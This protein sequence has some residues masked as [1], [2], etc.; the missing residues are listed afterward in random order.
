M[1][2]YQKDST[3]S[4]LNHST[5]TNMM[6]QTLIPKVVSETQSQTNATEV[7]I[8]SKLMDRLNKLNLGNN[9]RML[10]LIANYPEYGN[11]LISLFKSL[12]DLNKVLTPEIEHLIQR[13]ICHLGGV[14]NLL[15]LLSENN[16]S[17]DFISA[18]SLF[19]AAK[20][21]ETVAQAVRSL[22]EEDLLDTS[23]F[24]LMLAYP[25]ASLKMS[26]FIIDLQ[27]R[28]YSGPESPQIFVDKLR[29][30]MVQPLQMSTIMD[31][32]A[33][34]LEKNLYGFNLVDLFI[35][36][37][38]NIDQIY[39]GA[40]KL[41]SAP[42]FLMHY[43]KFL[44]KYPENA[45]IFA[46]NIMLLSSVSLLESRSATEDFINVSKLGLGA[47]H[48]LNHLHSAG[49]LDAESYKMVLQN[50]GIL[51]QEEVI[52][53]L[54]SLP[55]MTRFNKT[56]LEHMLHLLSRSLCKSTTDN[57]LNILEAHHFS[58]PPAPSIGTCL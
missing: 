53:S 16:I 12:K 34:L 18:E 54:S 30:S 45:N 31:L 46:K 51:D 2:G 14:I 41:I 43:F 13:N 11:R 1:G 27:D 28:A 5:S 17:P 48:F 32:L 39:K 8:S 57:F 23:S 42:D 50:N 38:S 52:G 20:A 10:H 56:E 49:M 26:Q 58:C 25:E 3:S 7:K 22:H 21:D 29:A 37:A 24:N 47:Y 9:P 6:F 44:E 15:G 55:L 19:K 35:R 33:F 36:N 4:D 40:K